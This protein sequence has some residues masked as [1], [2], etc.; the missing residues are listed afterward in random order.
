MRGG[1]ALT[2]VL[3]V[4]WLC[5]LVGGAVGFA[6]LPAPLTILH[7]LPQGHRVF[8]VDAPAHPRGGRAQREFAAAHGDRTDRSL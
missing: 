3:A 8:A 7:A 4:V 5:G 6:T 1:G 2:V